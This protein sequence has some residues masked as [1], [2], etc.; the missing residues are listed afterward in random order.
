MSSRMIAGAGLAF[1]LLATS[2]ASATTDPFEPEHRR[3]SA[4][5]A[6]LVISLTTKPNQPPAPAVRLGMGMRDHP[7]GNSLSQPR[8]RNVVELSLT[9]SGRPALH[10]GGRPLGSVSKQKLNGGSVLLTIGS[11]A[12]AA[13][14]AGVIIDASD[15]DRDDGQCMLPEQELCGD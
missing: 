3:G 4:G 7:G 8:L 9:G 10:L 1:S 13:L 11:L 12:A 6:G 5:F 15:E 14:L 2:P